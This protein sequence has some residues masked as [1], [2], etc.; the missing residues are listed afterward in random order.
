MANAEP[1]SALKVRA[2]GY[3]RI[4]GRQRL[5]GRRVALRPVS[6][7]AYSP[8][9]RVRRGDTNRTLS[10]AQRSVTWP[11]LRRLTQVVRIDSR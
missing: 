8:A 10:E 9:R 5:V 4:A 2:V 3:Q 11:D 1:R 6:S 7:T